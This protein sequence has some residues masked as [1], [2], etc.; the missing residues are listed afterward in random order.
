MPISAVAICCDDLG[1]MSDA[2]RLCAVAGLDVEVTA[3]TDVRRWWASAAAVLLDSTAAAQVVG[4]GVPRRAGVAVLTRVDDPADWR[5]A[6]AVGAEQLAVLPTDER[7]LLGGVLAVRDGA[8]GA[9]VVACLP[10]TGGAGAST[11]AAGLALAAARRGTATL[12]IDADPAGGGLDLLFGS[13]HAA[14]LRWPDVVG[15]AGAVPDAVPDGLLQPARGLSLLSWDRNGAPSQD[16]TSCWAS[17][18]PAARSGAE[19]VVID[20][21][22]AAALDNAAVDVVLLV[23]RAGVRSTVAAVQ[24]AQLV[25]PRCPDVRLIV[26]SGGRGALAAAQVAAALRLPLAAQL[27]EDHRMA[28]AADDGQ[29]SRLA[30]RRSLQALAADLCRSRGAAA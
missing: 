11:A 21:P 1:L 25:R 9:P 15:T 14:G 18:L 22:R 29:L 10:A 27:E 16:I 19:L 4:H 13:E 17:F 26:R 7:A 2:R 6:L 3:S 20:L 28:A 8:A 23:V 24:A 12:L 30:G 5:V